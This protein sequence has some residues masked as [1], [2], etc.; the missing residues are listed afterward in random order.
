MFYVEIETGTMYL[1]IVPP[2][3]SR[4]L[5]EFGLAWVWPLNCQDILLHVSR[6]GGLTSRRKKLWNVDVLAICWSLWL[7]MNNKIFEDIKGERYFIW[8]KIKYWI[9]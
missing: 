9:A 4:M 3:W 2:L 5:W 6:I 8:D 7:E 1:Y